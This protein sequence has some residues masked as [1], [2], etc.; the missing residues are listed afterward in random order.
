MCRIFAV[1]I[2]TWWLHIYD[3][4][5]MVNQRHIYG[6][7]HATCTR[8]GRDERGN[9]N[10][11]T[12]TRQHGRDTDAATRM[13]RHERGDTNA[14]TRT[15]RHGRGGLRRERGDTAA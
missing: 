2:L 15:R 4:T 5:V 8:H 3:D 7:M 11:A 13:R 14:A 9:T 12:R 6:D 10:A 1:K